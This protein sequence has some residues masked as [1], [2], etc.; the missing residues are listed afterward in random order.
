[1][2]INKILLQIKAN[3]YFNHDFTT[4]HRY[5]GICS[6]TVN[7]NGNHYIKQIYYIKPWLFGYVFAN[8]FT[9]DTIKHKVKINI[10]GR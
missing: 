4:D 6:K 5:H 7:V 8:V 10:T 1:M 2:R 9:S 3:N